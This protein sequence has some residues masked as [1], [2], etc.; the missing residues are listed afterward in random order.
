MKKKIKILDDE[1]YSISIK[2]NLD[3]DETL[4]IIKDMERRIMH[5]NDMF[6]KMDSFRRLPN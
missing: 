6:R 2:C 1:G 3:A 5:M 4:G